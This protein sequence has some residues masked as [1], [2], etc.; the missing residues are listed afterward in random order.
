MEFVRTVLSSKKALATIVSILV[1]LIGRAG[2]NIS[3]EM[4]LPVV[5]AIAAYV[6]AQGI[7]DKG[8]EAVKEAAKAG[9]VTT[10]DPS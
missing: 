2:L 9:M 7:A 1:W 6:L 4:L 8:K 10:A 5:G 3:E